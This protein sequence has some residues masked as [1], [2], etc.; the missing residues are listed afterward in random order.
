MVVQVRLI[1]FGFKDF[2]TQTA[3]F[4]ES[5]PFFVG[6]NSRVRYNT[7]KNSILLE[8]GLSEV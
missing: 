7:E 3:S 4:L 8:N 5:L 6:I 2:K 1:R